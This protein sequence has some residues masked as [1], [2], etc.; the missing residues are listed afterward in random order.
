MRDIFLTCLFSCLFQTTWTRADGVNNNVVVIAKFNDTVTLECDD[1]SGD[2][3]LW[4]K[5]VMTDYKVG[6]VIQRQNLKTFPIDVS[7]VTLKK[8]H[9]HVENGVLN[10]GQVEWSDGGHYSCHS[11]KRDRISLKSWTLIILNE[12]Q[13]ISNSIFYEGI[14]LQVRNCS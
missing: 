11:W 4:K 12:Q 6:D 14:P 10:L 9:R 13:N 5:R 3:I 8:R 7:Q 2:H 1:V